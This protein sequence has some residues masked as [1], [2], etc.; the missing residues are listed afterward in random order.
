MVFCL[1]P[2]IQARPKVTSHVGQ[3]ANW[4]KRKS[5]LES[6]NQNVMSMKQLI[7]SY[8]QK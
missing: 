5:L 7:D 4:G 2:S 1:P 8:E 6:V 3:V